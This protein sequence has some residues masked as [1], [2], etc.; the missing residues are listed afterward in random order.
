[1][2]D[3]HL[4]L[5]A[6]VAPRGIS[7]SRTPNLGLLRNTRLPSTRLIHRFPF[8]IPIRERA[9]STHAFCFNFCFHVGENYR[10][11]QHVVT[12]DSLTLVLYSTRTSPPSRNLRFS[13]YP[14]FTRL[15]HL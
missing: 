9:I 11:Y 1:M 2:I 12:V 5:R 8:P 13:G 14:V 7:A 4:T 15:V 6:A 3:C 10:V